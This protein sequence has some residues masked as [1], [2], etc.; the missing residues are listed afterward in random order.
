MTLRNQRA[1]SLRYF[2]NYKVGFFVLDIILS[3]VLVFTIVKMVRTMV[4]RPNMAYDVPLPVPHVPEPVTVQPLSYYEP[5]I[6]AKIFGSSSE[7]TLESKH[8]A[9]SLESLPKTTL[10]LKLVGTVI[11]PEVGRYAI[12]VDSGL[13]KADTY[14]PGDLIAPGV[15]LLE[16]YPRRV[17]ILRDGKRE[18]LE[19]LYEEQPG[20]VM[21][22][23]RRSQPRPP[24]TR[25]STTVKEV[26]RTLLESNFSGL[27]QD[28][29]NDVQF[30][31]NKSFRGRRGLG[32]DKVAPGSP[33]SQYGVRSGDV[34]LEINGEQV[35]GL[36]DA[37]ALVP[38]LKDAD[39]IKVTVG[40]G[41]EVKTLTYK[42]R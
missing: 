32:I 23:S 26:D 25:P 33:L 18:I 7:T 5:L 42:I 39:E 9:I 4:F 36:A 34:I 22:A 16:V 24:R 3:V 1:A 15:E 31:Q 29:F 41:S 40:R 30:S 14:K 21:A 12:V 35:K 10:N 27:A 8:S 37:M 19:M 6:K 38:G 17:V 20:K 28:V 11:D 2:L 13:N